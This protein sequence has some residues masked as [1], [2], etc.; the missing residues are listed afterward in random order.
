MQK[1]AILLVGLFLI[2]GFLV[3]WIRQSS[4]S[5]NLRIVYPVSTISPVPS[6]TE[7]L[8]PLPSPSAQASP[9][10]KP[11]PK[12][13]VKPTPLVQSR[14]MKIT[15][16]RWDENGSPGNGIAYPHSEYPQTIHEVSTGTGTFTDPLSAAARADVF[17][18]GQRLYAPYIKKYLIIEDICGDCGSN[19]IDIWLE[20]NGKFQAQ[21][22]EC[23]GKYTSESEVIE[24]NPPTGRPVNT[25]FIFNPDT[26][27]CL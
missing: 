20:S 13:T 12:P 9:T 16:W 25:G 24:I 11:T 3:A 22:D 21:V 1:L 7:L 19:H 18:A 17:P 8:T 26:G 14:S 5:N 27:V 2:G 23:A 6:P 4:S 10:I 15:Y